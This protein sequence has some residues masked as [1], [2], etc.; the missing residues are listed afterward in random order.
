MQGAGAHAP[1][2]TDALLG[3]LKVE[4][5]FDRTDDNESYWLSQERHDAILKS[6]VEDVLPGIP[7]V[8]REC[9][10]PYV[11]H[12]MITIRYWMNDVPG[13][14]DVLYKVTMAGA[15]ANPEQVRG[16]MGG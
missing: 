14:R 10:P 9:F 7:A 11:P 16:L 15:G 1:E 2:P 3:L 8:P 6:L 12:T 5:F 13:Y 4:V